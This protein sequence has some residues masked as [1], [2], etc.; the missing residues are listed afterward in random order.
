MNMSK[1]TKILIG[2]LTLLVIFA[3]VAYNLYSADR[4]KVQPDISS[5]RSIQ[6]TD[7]LITVDTGV[8]TPDLRRI[9]TVRSGSIIIEVG[10][11]EFDVC[12]VNYG[13]ALHERNLNQKLPTRCVVPHEREQLELP[14]LNK[15]IDFSELE[16]FCK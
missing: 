1:Q 7:S 2:V 3:S 15:G 8:C 4:P 13:P 5:G 16:E 9:D 10:G 14:I 12:L 11:K 6:V